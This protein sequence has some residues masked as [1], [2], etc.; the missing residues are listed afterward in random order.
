MRHPVL[1]TAPAADIVSRAEAKVQCRIDADDDEENGLVDRLIAQATA[2]FDGW[3]G[4]LGRCLISQT[5]RQDCCAWPASG[6][7]R[8]PF[9]DVQSVTVTYT[10][11]DSASQTVSSSLYEIGEDA[12]SSYVRFK[13]A[14]T[15]PSLDDDLEFPISIELIAGYG[16]AASDVPET[17]RGAA[18]GLIGHWYEHRESVSPEPMT[19]VPQFV[20]D[21]IDLHRRNRL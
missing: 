20:D 11:A 4:R 10:D 9:P 19:E 15:S 13:N 12:I 2:K 7:L 1:V 14:F 18:L 21:L 17:I 3:A 8:L 5:W 6:K 16:D